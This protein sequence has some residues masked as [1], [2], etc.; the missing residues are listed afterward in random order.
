MA[1]KG[2]MAKEPVLRGEA[3]KKAQL[4]KRAAAE[5]RPET[6]PPVTGGPKRERAMERLSPGVYRGERGGL[7]TQGGRELPRQ[8]QVNP[9]AIPAGPQASD[10]NY[11]LK[12]AQNKVLQLTPEQQQQVQAMPMRP[13][14][15]APPATTPEMVN[16]MP[17]QPYGQVQGGAMYRPL[18]YWANQQMIQQRQQQVQPAMQPMIQPPLKQG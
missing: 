1:R 7:V 5:G 18:P 17:M 14:F 6:S 4:D 12:D 11:L 10:Y 8:Q 15:Q 16:N 3:R 9:W 2:A 13:Q